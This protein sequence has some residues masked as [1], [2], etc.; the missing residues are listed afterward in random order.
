MAF[1][2]DKVYNF[3]TFWLFTLT[4]FIIILHILRPSQL[5]F[6]MCCY[7]ISPFICLQVCFFVKRNNLRGV[8]L[9][10]L[11]LSF[12]FFFGYFNLYFF[13][14][15]IGNSWDI[16]WGEMKGW[17][18]NHPV[19]YYTG[20]YIFGAFFSALPTLAHC[21]NTDNCALL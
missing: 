1:Y 8:F 5:Y 10:F 11:S 17:R 2:I 18:K 9:L 20:I 16:S 6:L 12:S 13:E 14:C 3:H 7:D 15:Y 21:Y 4:R 19:S